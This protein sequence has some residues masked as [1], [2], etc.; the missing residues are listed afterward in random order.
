[1]NSLK[2]WLIR[3]KKGR[4]AILVCFSAHDLYPTPESFHSNINFIGKIIEKSLYEIYLVC[5]LWGKSGMDDHL[6]PR[7][8]DWPN[9]LLPILS[10]FQAFACIIQDQ[11]CLLIKVTWRYIQISKS[12]FTSRNTLIITLAPSIVEN[13]T[14]KHSKIIT[15]LPNKECFL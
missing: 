2:F 5:F 4:E 15:V 8:L 7:F 12:S 1:M 13:F 3:S 10:H 9:R 11:G 14:K 6:G